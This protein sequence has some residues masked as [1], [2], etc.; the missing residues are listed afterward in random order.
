VAR[1][2]LGEGP[3]LGRGRLCVVELEEDLAQVVVERDRGVGG[4]VDPAG[5]RRI[6]LAERDLVRH[7]DHRLQAGAAGLT[8]VVGGGVVRQLRAEHALA[9]EVEVPAVLEH[10]ASGDLA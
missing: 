2:N 6:L 8:D 4:G 7:L 1:A 10:G 3:Q 9:G 5:N